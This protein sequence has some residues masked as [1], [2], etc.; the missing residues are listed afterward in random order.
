MN[1]HLITYGIILNYNSSEESI[2]LY[3][4]LQRLDDDSLEVLVIDNASQLE[5]RNRLMEVIPE[6]HLVFNKKNKGYAAGNNVGI[7]KA[8]E[9]GAAYIWILNPDIRID[10]ESLK[11]LKE[12][13]MADTKLAAVGPRILHRHDEKVIFSDGELMNKRKCLTK[14]KNH[15]VSSNEVA[16]GIDYSIDYIDGSSILLNSEAIKE[17]GLLPEEYFLYFEETDWCF[18]AKKKGW[19]LAV[20]SHAKVYNLTSEKAKTFHYYINR[21]RL[22]FSNNYLSNFNEIRNDSVIGIINEFF[23]RFRGRYLKPY[24]FSR[25]KGILSGVIKT[26]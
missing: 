8:L 6:A 4:K 10:N 21:N 15:N 14:H 26:I 25:L 7:T 5:D 19:V 16:A 1:T 12:T 11:I 20:N 24:Y 17:I 13:L 3:G 9:N 22:I 2:A 18:K 23:A